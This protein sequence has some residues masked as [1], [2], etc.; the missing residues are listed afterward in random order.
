MASKYFHYIYG[1]EE[2][3]I[4]LEYV[5]RIVK[6]DGLFRIYQVGSGEPLKFPQTNSSAL[7]MWRYFMSKSEKS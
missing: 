4:E 2:G 1:D 3:V 5:T 7:D 6:S